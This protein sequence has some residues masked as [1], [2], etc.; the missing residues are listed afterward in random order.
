MSETM[1]HCEHIAGLLPWLLNGTLEQAA[2]VEVRA[3]LENCA[4]CQRAL[5]ETALAW[6]V[7]RQHIPAAVLVEYAFERAAPDFDPALLQEHLAACEACAE[8]L[9]QARASRR[10]AEEAETARLIPFPARPAREWRGLALAA[11]LAGLAL[12][13]TWFW[14]WQR[15]RGEQTLLRAQQRALR[16][17]VAGLE[18]ENRQLREA[19]QSQA[20]SQTAELQ[21]RVRE[22]AAPQLNVPLFD[23]YP[24]ELARRSTA[25]G[26]NEIRLPRQARAVTLILNSQSNPLTRAVSLQIVNA[27]GAI[28][29]RAAQLTRQASGEFTLSLPADFLPPGRYTLQLYAPSGARLESFDLR[30]RR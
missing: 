19:G 1:E 18:T 12:L 2:A 22:L 27:R 11:C 8:E 30:W 24:R 14:T 15:A 17:R 16:E 4:P 23:L 9:A 10:W 5:A 3:H 21:A 26:L 28:V 6:T 20:T 7:R 29:W 25:A 13:G